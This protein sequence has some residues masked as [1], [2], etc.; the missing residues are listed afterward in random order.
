MANKK[1]KGYQGLFL[2]EK[3]QEKLVE[4]QQKGLSDITKDMHITFKF[5]ETE[6]YPQ[7]LMGKELVEEYR[8]DENTSGVFVNPNGQMIV[9][10]GFKNPEFKIPNET[11]K[12]MLNKI[13][14]KFKGKDIEK[15]RE[16]QTEH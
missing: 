15:N 7:E 6:P 9:A 5:G 1:L 16:N 14:S 3:T 10:G 13:E 11:I 12:G 8:I 4:L 2:D